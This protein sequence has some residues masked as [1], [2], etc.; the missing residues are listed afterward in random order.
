MKKIKV[1]IVDKKNAERM[2]GKTIAITA[3]DNITNFTGSITRTFEITPCDIT[4]GEIS[5]KWEHIL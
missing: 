5:G 4:G 1:G 3:K 2:S